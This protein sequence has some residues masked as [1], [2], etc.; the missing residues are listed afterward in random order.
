MSKTRKRYGLYLPLLLSAALAAPTA[1]AGWNANQESIAGHPTWIY[2]PDGAS[3]KRPLFI[4]LHGCDQTNTQLKDWGNWV[5]TAESY[6]AVVALPYVGSK[7][8]PGNSSAKCWDYDGAND[9]S[10]HVAELVSLAGTLKDRNALNID[11]NQIYVVGLSSGASMALQVA[12]K[13]PD[14]IAGVG[15]IAGPSVGSAQSNALQSKQILGWIDGNNVSRGIQK[16]QSMAGSKASHFATQIAN[17]SYGDMDRDG[18]KARYSYS[19]GAT[20]N[21]GQYLLVS[22]KWSEDNAAILKSIYGTTSLGTGAAVQGGLGTQKQASKDGNV[23]LA[24]TEIHNVGHA[25]P[26]GSGQANSH[27]R[28][29]V[30]MAQSGLNYPDYIAGWMINNNLRAGNPSLTLNA[31]TVSGGTLTVTGTATDNGSITNVATALL[32]HDGSSYVQVASHASV[33]V[34]AGGGFSDSY[35]SLADGWYQVKVTATDNDGR[36]S[37]STT[38]ETKVGN[39]PPLWTCRE[40]NAANYYHVQAGRAYVCNSWYACAVGS[41]DNLGLNNT[42][43]MNVLAETS[44]GYFKKGSCAAN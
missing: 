44:A 40:H 42:Y 19:S 37:T 34:N 8:W 33:S 18:S 3:G 22:T 30:W 4:A 14:L 25:F 28:G 32:K 15:A 31:P 11:P 9:G 39:P 21:A 41:G 1:L 6:G 43:T 10:G 20:A 5:S 27:T 12:C 23:R 35:G 16:C 36:K 7:V 29:G 26:A 38:A 17:I 2:T 24:L 13:A